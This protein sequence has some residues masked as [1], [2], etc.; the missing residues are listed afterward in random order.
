ME[1]TVLVTDLGEYRCPPD[2]IGPDVALK[3][4]SLYATR[5]RPRDAD[6]QLANDTIHAL[7]RLDHLLAKRGKSLK[8][9]RFD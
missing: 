2:L 8:D 5:T 4:E 6:E 7:N 9:L 3:G 1:I